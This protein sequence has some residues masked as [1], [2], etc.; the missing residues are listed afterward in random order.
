V[1]DTPK[2]DYSTHQRVET[3]QV[4]TRSTQTRTVQHKR[5]SPARC[6]CQPSQ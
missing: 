4:Q 5:A 2:W 6:T 1:Q 3:A